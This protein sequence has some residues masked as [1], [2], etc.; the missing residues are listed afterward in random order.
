MIDNIT[1]NIDPNLLNLFIEKITLYI[2]KVIT[3]LLVLLIG[4]WIAGKIR[5]ILKKAFEKTEFDPAVETFLESILTF[6]IKT[7]IVLAAL[8]L[9]G[10]PMASFLAILG[11]AGLAIGL[12]LQGSL[13]NFA[14][15][16]IILIFKPFKIGDFIEAQGHSGSVKEISIINTTLLTGDNKTV[17]IPN[18]KLSNA[19]IVN[20]SAQ[21]KRRI[22]WNIG[23]DYGD[24]IDQAKAL[25]NDILKAE[26]RIIKKDGTLVAVS[27]LGDNAVIIKVRAWAKSGDH[28]STY[29]DTLE[30]IKKTFDKEGLNFPFPQSEVHMKKTS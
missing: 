19:S 5:K 26:K 23:I 4:F 11:A 24:D 8:N 15:G 13:S 3:A 29:L 12:A 21:K 1:Q 16:V 18:G 9:V 22:E 14:G 2:P 27:E 30:T 25:L 17:I 7:M 20:Y 28:W 10:I 6:L